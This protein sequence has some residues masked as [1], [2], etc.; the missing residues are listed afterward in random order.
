MPLWRATA[1]GHSF[2]DGR[3]RASTGVTLRQIW[4]RFAP[5]YKSSDA[6]EFHP[7]MTLIFVLRTIFGHSSLR[8]R[9]GLGK[10]VPD[11]STLVVANPLA[12]GLVDN[13]DQKWSDVKRAGFYR[14]L[15]FFKQRGRVTLPYQR[16]GI[17]EAGDRMPTEDDSRSQQL[18]ANAP[19]LVAN[20]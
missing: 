3:S 2:L 15:I 20:G 4:V 18:N 11:R 8:W 17:S 10:W 5:K 16:N 7:P 6:R 19:P 9:P 1:D 13:R 14:V 12:Q